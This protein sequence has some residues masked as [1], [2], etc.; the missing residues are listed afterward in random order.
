M[1]IYLLNPCCENILYFLLHRRGGVDEGEEYR[2]IYYRRQERKSTIQAV[3][4]NKI[5]TAKSWE[6]IR[7]E[8]T[9]VPTFYLKS[10]GKL[11]VWGI[12]QIIQYKHI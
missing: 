3:Q 11:H 12:L 8:T 5:V 10:G 4:N 2:H 6:A 9:R 7:Y 1:R